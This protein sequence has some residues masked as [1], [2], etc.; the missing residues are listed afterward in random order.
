MALV[1]TGVHISIHV[2]LDRVFEGDAKAKYG[3][4]NS[5]DDL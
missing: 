3:D 5:D 1:H 4:C 2:G